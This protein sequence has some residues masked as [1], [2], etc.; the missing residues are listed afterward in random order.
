MSEIPSMTREELDARVKELIEAA[1]PKRTKPAAP[2]PD[3]AKLGELEA[4]NVNNNL[5]LPMITHEV[6]AYLDVKLADNEYVAVWANRDQRRIGELEAQGYEFLRPEHLEKGFKLPLKFNSEGMYIYA[7]VVAMRVHKRILY[8]K[9][10]KIQEISVRQ[11][12]GAQQIAKER[13]AKEDIFR[14]PNLEGAFSKGSMGF[15][16]PSL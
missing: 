11:L 12:R 9:R 16:E 4:L 13:V 14:D 2:E 1:A 3:W 7:D 6:P 15:F 10:R 5:N 8:S